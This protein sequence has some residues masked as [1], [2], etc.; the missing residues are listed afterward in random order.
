MDYRRI[1][2]IGTALS[3][4]LIGGTLL[5]AQQPGD[6]DEEWS[7]WWFGLFGG[8][9][10]TMPSGGISGF[11]SSVSPADPDADFSRFEEGSGLGP[12]FG[13]VIEYNP[14]TLLGFHALIGYNGLPID[15]ETIST[16]VGNNQTT[17]ETLSI[18]P[19]YL[20]I[21]PS[22][23]LNLGGRFLHVLIGPTANIEL[24]RGSDYTSID[25]LGTNVQSGDLQGTRGFL[26]GLKGGVGYDFALQGAESST[27][28]L[29][30]P[31]VEYHLGLQELFDISEDNSTDLTT[32]ALRIGLQLKFGSRAVPPIITDPDGNPIVY[33]F[34]VDAPVVIA[35]SR[36][37]EETFPLRNYIFFD[38]GTTTIPARYTK[39][40]RDDA[41][42]FR[43]EQ[44]LNDEPATGPTSGERA[45]RQM[46]VYY[47][48][49]NVFG[50]RLRRNPKIAARLTGAADGD[51]AKGKEMAENVKNYL[52]QTF[53][54]SAD[55]ITVVSQ[56]MP[57][58]KSGSGG[59]MG[60][61]KAMIAAENWR[62]EIDAEP[63]AALEPVKIV[64]R[65]AAPIGNDVIFRI[66]GDD[67]V[68]SVS[69]AVTERD[70]ETRTFGPYD[71]DRDVRVDARD[72]LGEQREGRYTA[73]TTYTL[74]D[75][76]TYESK[77]QEFRLVRAD[78]DEEQSGLR[79]SI[80]FEFDKS[81]TVQTYES[82]LRSEVAVAIPNGAN[83]IV[84]G[85]TDAT[86][87]PEYNDALS[88]RRVEETRKILTDELTKMGRTVTFDSYGFG[89]NE[90]RSPFGNSQP[91]RRYYNRTVIIEIVPGG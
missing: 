65:E 45:K 34:R 79:Y 66:N 91:E 61:D 75:G 39:L 25:S 9:N 12:V 76:S 22:L 7:D 74:D 36:R 89:E 48:V 80:L 83:V 73:R 77:S 33:D 17:T 53:G 2:S 37:V 8:I 51:A 47:N 86:G 16:D 19:A 28:I 3:L 40:G 55:R 11:N 59:S 38:P 70:G 35:E 31:F 14:G 15:F 52:V 84:H 13:G 41:A 20:A 29:L 46:D 60:E 62:V 21:E 5:H 56:A 54:L 63:R 58:H 26:L 90:T 32:N 71:G 50:D 30:T 49:L 4:L 42:S 82:F 68:A 57:P 88:D 72:L 69:I 27:Q 67:Q 78:P 81:A 18:S 43:E 1:A 44:L 87:K 24:S 10:L 64:S 6:A 85:H 23:R